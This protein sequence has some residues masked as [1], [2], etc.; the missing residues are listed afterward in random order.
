[1]AFLWSL[2][3]IDGVRLREPTDVVLADAGNLLVTPVYFGVATVVDGRT[4]AVVRRTDANDVLCEVPGAWVALAAD[5][6]GLLTPTDV[7]VRPLA[8][9]GTWRVPLFTTVCGQRGEDVVVAVHDIHTAEVGLI[10][11]D[12]RS[13]APVWHI[14]LGAHQLAR[15]GLFVGELPR[16]VPIVVVTEV[17]SDFVAHAVVV[18]LDHGTVVGRIP[19]DDLT[20]YP[21][22]AAGRA[23]VLSP[24]AQRLLALDPTTG[25][26]ERATHW[27]GGAVDARPDDIRDGRLWIAGPGR[28]ARPDDLPWAVIDLSTGRTLREHGGLASRDVALPTLIP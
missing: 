19:L 22:T 15:D 14:G 5:G 23:T 12:G 13:G 11:F 6:V 16:F 21:L 8:Q 4:G 28:L 26:P 20:S 27:P 1:M 24:T 17:D 7:T 2:S 10:R 18:D 25:Q 9:G 3:A